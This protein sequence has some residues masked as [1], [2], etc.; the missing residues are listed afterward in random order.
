MYV[1]YHLRADE[2]TADV[3]QNI[4]NTYHDRELV[5][6]SKDTYD[7]PERV[8]KNAEYL[9]QLEESKQELEAGKG[10]VKT[11]AELEAMEHA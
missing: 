1:T 4:K 7:E 11:M 8:R 2:I 5:V 6:L 3:I 9:A 10:I